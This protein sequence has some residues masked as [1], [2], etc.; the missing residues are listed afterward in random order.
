LYRKD[1]VDLLKEILMDPPQP[2]Q[3]PTDEDNPAALV[4]M[5][6][7]LQDEGERC[8]I[9]LSRLTDLID[10]GA[11]NS[12]IDENGKKVKVSNYSNVQSPIQLL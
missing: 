4:R 11:N 8:E 1:L 10:C 9:N 5:L 12:I 3:N 2:N 6:D 7:F